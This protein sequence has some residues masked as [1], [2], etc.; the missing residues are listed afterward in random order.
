MMNIPAIFF[1]VVGV[2]LRSACLPCHLFALLL[3]FLG[4]LCCVR[5]RPPPRHV[6]VTGAASGMGRGLAIFYAAQPETECLSLTDL[7]FAGLEETREAC[8]AAA[9][10]RRPAPGVDSALL[11]AISRIDIADAAAVRAY[12]KECDA[13]P[14][15]PLD[16]VLCVAGVIEPRIGGGRG[17]DDIELGL[18]ALVNVNVLGVANTVLPALEAMRR[19]GRGQI[20]VLSS[21][22]ALDGLN[23]LYPAYAASKS[24]VTTWVL[25]LR[26]RLQHSGVTL[27]VF[28]PGAVATPLLTAPPGLDP[29]YDPTS[30]APSWIVHAPCIEM[31]VEQAAAAWASGLASNEAL[32]RPHRC[33][34]L[35][36]TDPCLDCPLDARDLLVRGRCHVL[37]GW[38]APADPKHA[39]L[40]CEEP[41]VVGPAPSSSANGSNAATC[42]VVNGPCDL[43]ECLPV[44]PATGSAKD[45]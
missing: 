38:R 13:L 31:S 7:N 20:G 10:A 33:Y 32:T 3:E 25:G 12:V 16:L 37:W 24:F 9:R 18:R 45:Q 41:A 40:T 19:R 35:A 28:A 11:V 22:A 34:A 42:A 39:W 17:A 1:A 21:L 30:F 43:G 27:N 23:A 6:L 8:A 15:P 14:R 36:C 26:A 29:R 4:S 44:V 5:R 2:I